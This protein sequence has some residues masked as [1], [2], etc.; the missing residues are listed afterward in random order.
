MRLR[1]LTQ[2]LADLRG[3]H[4]YIAKDNPAAARRVVG[5]IRREVE[6]LATEPEIGRI[7][8]L[9][10]SREFVIRQYPYIVAYCVKDDEVQLLLVVHT[11][12]RWPKQ[13]P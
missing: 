7:G 13:M 1:W 10:G 11:S 8:R 3:I 4:D 6:I 12:R 2:A 5:E 9:T